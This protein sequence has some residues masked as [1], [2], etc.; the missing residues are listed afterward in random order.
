M[1]VK[2]FLLAAAMVA[3]VGSAAFAQTAAAPVAP[4]GPA[5]APRVPDS[6]FALNMAYRDI[7]RAELAGATGH[8]VDAAKTHYRS[9]IDRRGRNDDAGASAEAR[10]ASDLARVALDE[11][12]P[13]E[14]SGPKDIPAPPTP[15]PVAGGTAREQRVM[16]N[17]VSMPRV[18]GFD[19]PQMLTLGGPEVFMSMHGGSYSATGL[20]EILKVETGAEARQLAERAVDANAAAQKAALAGNVGEAAR[21]TRLS[22]DLSAA[23]HDIAALNHPELRHGNRMIRIER[24]ATTTM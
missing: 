4:A 8:Y 22:N 5:M 1:R 2:S 20:A 12:P 10:I 18:M 15:R 23:V 14:R 3:V 19:M 6:A 17:G 13:A 24:N 11:R 16:M 7:G 21:Q 9:A